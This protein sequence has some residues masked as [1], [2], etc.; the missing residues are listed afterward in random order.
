MS[1]E[2]KLLEDLK[3]A[4]KARDSLKVETLRMVRA[5][6]KD[7]QIAKRA[8]LSED[9]QMGV[10]GNAAKKRREALEMYRESDRE[11]LIQKEQ[12]E[13]D[14]ISGYLPRQL[15]RAETEKIVK[16]IVHEVG[17]T[18][19]QDLGKVMGPAMQQLK[20]K[21]DGKLVQELVREIL[22]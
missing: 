16:G 6:L 21:A 11:D 17:A 13:L 2:E 20:G 22:S 14:I 1:I 5:Q 18:T 19:M 12:A 15:S 10:I 4:M 7:A 3:T 9:E 8:P